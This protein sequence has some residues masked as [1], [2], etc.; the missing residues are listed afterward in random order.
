VLSRGSNHQGGSRHGSGDS[1]GSRHHH[2]QPIGVRPHLR[3][4]VTVEVLFDMLKTM[5][6]LL[7]ASNVSA[8]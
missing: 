5:Q 8:D 7:T 6:S 3:E 1:E 2:G 4:P